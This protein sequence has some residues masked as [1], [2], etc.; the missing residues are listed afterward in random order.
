MASLG[1]TI[2][3]VDRFGWPLQTA[4]SSA[5]V[6]GGAVFTAS[7]GLQTYGAATF[8]GMSLFNAATSGVGILVR[9]FQLFNDTTSNAAE[10]Y[11]TTIDPAFGTPLTPQ[12]HLAGGAASAIAAGC[13]Y[14]LTGLVKPAGLPFS[15]NSV[16][17]NSSLSGG[18]NLL[19]AP[20]WLP[21]GHGIAGYQ[22][23]A[24]G[25]G[26]EGN[27]IYEEFPA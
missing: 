9:A 20:V 1:P 23:G 5:D 19:L 16:S 10:A 4:G 14:A 8:A 11:L 18:G 7:L 17:I 27:I 22:F 15:V 26:I 24:T 21:P 3:P 12:N 6:R 25:D 13:S 2:T